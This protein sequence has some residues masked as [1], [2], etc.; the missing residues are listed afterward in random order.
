M[1]GTLENIALGSSD[2]L[3]GSVK[4]TMKMLSMIFRNI[5][6]LIAM[7]IFVSGLKSQSLTHAFFLKVSTI[8]KQPANT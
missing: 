2:Y 1:T 4:A 8:S 5:R 3:V 6:T 7:N